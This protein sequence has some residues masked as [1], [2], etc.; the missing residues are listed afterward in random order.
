MPKIKK[1]KYKVG[2]ASVVGP[3]SYKGLKDAPGQVIWVP[4]EKTKAVPKKLHK[5]T[6]KDSKVLRK[7]SRKISVGINT[8]D[9]DDTDEESEHEEQ[10]AWGFVDG[11][12]E[13]DELEYG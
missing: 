10:G 11:D 12:M 1:G 7:A 2:K 5:N 4:E 6:P 13:A 9:D 3:D 8:I